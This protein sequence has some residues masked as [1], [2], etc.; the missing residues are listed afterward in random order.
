MRQNH[1]QDY[2]ARQSIMKAT[3]QLNQL[4]QSLWLD[5]ITRELLDS[6]TLKRY[7]DDLTVTG[8]TSNPTIF[9]NA[10]TH[11]KSYDPEIREL[12]SRGFSN[13]RSRISPAPPRCSRQSI[14]ARAPSMDGFRWRY[15][16]CWLTTPRPPCRK[17]SGCTR[18]PI[19]ATCSSRFPA[20]KRDCPRSRKQFFPG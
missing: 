15:R 7:I 3:Q 20:P 2:D 9:D 14:S 17:R 1:K 18:K 8:L 16:R 13:S 5:N 19:A 11:S 10:I 12:V 4:G 6:G